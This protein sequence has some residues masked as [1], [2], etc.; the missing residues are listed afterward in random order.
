MSAESNC[1]RGLRCESCSRLF[2]SIAD[3]IGR[4]GYHLDPLDAVHLFFG[5]RGSGDFGERR[6]LVVSVGDGVSCF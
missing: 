1:E 6:I 5:V 2:S 3:L 4:D